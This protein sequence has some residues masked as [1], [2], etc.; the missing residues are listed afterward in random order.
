M[1]RSS[2]ISV[3]WGTTAL[4]VALCRSVDDPDSATLV[5][6]GP[7]IAEAHRSWVASGLPEEGRFAFYIHLLEPTIQ[8]VMRRAD[9]DPGAS[10]PSL[11]IISGM[12]SSSLG[13]RELPYGRVPFRLDPSSS[14]FGIGTEDSRIIEAFPNPN[15]DPDGSSTVLLISGVRTDLDV[16]RGEETQLLGLAKLGESDGLVILP[17]TH[18]KHAVVENG[19]LTDFRTYLTGEL[20]GLLAQQSVLRGVLDRDRSSVEVDPAFL[21]GVRDGGSGALLHELFRIRADALIR[22]E[23]PTACRNRL[24]GLLIGAELAGLA[25]GSS[26][27]IILAATDPLGTLYQAALEQLGL[28]DRIRRVDDKVMRRAWLTAHRLIRDR[29]VHHGGIPS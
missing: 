23:A 15:A 8:E 12:A 27:R 28:G 22:A 25:L 4:R 9:D 1:L 18:S 19:V 6:D 20:Y 11:L 24:S 26:R 3:D 10:P 13:I 29:W 14:D 17:G 16:M 2:W 7:G 21:R 5:E